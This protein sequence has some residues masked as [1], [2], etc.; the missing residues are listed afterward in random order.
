MILLE[1]TVYKFIEKNKTL[2]PLYNKIKSL[3]NPENVLQCPILVFTYFQNYK[4]IDLMESISNDLK[5]QDISKLYKIIKFLQ[6]NVDHQKGIIENISYNPNIKIVFILNI[7]L[8]K[9]PHF[10]HKYKPD[11]IIKKIKEFLEIYINEDNI[12]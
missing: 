4:I 6:C 7:G 8:D 5:N 10:I 2:T 9:N 12:S 3:N 11:Y 1:P